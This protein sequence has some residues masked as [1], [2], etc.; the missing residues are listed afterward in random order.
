MAW[1]AGANPYDGDRILCSIPYESV[2]MKE[3]SIYSMSNFIVKVHRSGLK[4]TP[5]KYKLGV[6]LKTNVS[7]LSGDVFPF[8]HFLF[9]PFREIDEMCASNNIFLIDYIGQV[10]G[11]EAP[12]DI[13][14]KTGQSSKRLRLYLEDVEL[15]SP[16][17]F[18]SSV[19]LK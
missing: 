6:F 9:T 12:E 1:M 8:C 7:I 2:S 3:N 10:V 15:S 5:F 14:I 13:I 4:V 19:M 16:K 11:K 18:V 17:F